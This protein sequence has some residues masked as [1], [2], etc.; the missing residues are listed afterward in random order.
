[1][2]NLEQ[3]NLKTTDELVTNVNDEGINSVIKNIND[4]QKEAQLNKTEYAEIR[5]L[6]PIKNLRTDSYYDAKLLDLM[7]WNVLRILLTVMTLGIGGPWGECLYLKYKMNHMVLNGKRLKF[8][9][10]GSEL[11]VEQFKWTFLTMITFGIYA[12]WI[13]VKKTSWVVSNIYFEDEECVK[14]ESLFGGSVLKY[15]GINILCFIIT[16]VSFG[17]LSSIL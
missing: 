7:G 6:N 10:D 13:P 14:G 8:V 4:K 2:D 15:V 11:F 5:K 17:L 9:G 3:K 16:I 12:L 1:M